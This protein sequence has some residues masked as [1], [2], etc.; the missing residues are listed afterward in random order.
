M[1]KYEIIIYWSNADNVFIAEIPELK[2][3]V[4]HGETQD[5]ALKEVSL[6]VNEWIEIAKENCWDIPVPKGRLIYA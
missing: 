5:E 1:N 6:V 2:G 3:C 4:A